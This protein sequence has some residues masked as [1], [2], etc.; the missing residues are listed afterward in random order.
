M[1]GALGSRRRLAVAASILVVLAALAG[2]VAWR[3]RRQGE[4]TPARAVERY[5]AALASGD[6]D[7]VR[8]GFTR[9]SS[10]AEVER[11][12]RQYGRS[13]A[14][15]ATFAVLEPVVPGAPRAVHLVFRDGTD[16]LL[17]RHGRTGW[18]LL[19]EAPP[20]PGCEPGSVCDADSGIP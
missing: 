19:A 18:L 9:D 3:L 17:V 15:G 10:D 20:G 12:I 1:A 6:G 2:A 8:D 16:D 5:L 4:P 11:R 13:R 14:V 7:A